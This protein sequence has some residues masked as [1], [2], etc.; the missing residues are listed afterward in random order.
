MTPAVSKALTDFLKEITK[1]AKEIRITVKAVRE[2][3]E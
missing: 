1:L 3:E 2:E